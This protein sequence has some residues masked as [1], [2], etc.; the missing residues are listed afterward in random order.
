MIV[1]YARTFITDLAPGLPERN[2]KAAGAERICRMR[3]L[4]G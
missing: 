2:L 1:S 4:A 3:S